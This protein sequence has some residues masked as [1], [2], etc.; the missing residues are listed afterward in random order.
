[1][2]N[3]H[4][5]KFVLMIRIKEHFPR[6]RAKLSIVAPMVLATPLLMLVYHFNGLGYGTGSDWVLP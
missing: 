4:H 3:N 6:R 2:V 1:M 5:L